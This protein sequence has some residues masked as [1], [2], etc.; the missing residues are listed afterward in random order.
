MSETI[1]FLGL[2][3]ASRIYSKRGAGLI[4]TKVIAVDNVTLGITRGETLALVGES[5]SGKSTTGRMLLGLEQPDTGKLISGI[6]GEKLLQNNKDTIVRA[7]FQNPRSSLNPRRR[8]SSL[9]RESLG[10]KRSGMSRKQVGELVLKTLEEVGL[11][12]EHS[13]VFPHSLSGGQQQRVAIAAAIISEPDFVILDEP[14]SALDPS[15]AAQVL[16]LLVSLGNRRGCGFLFITHDLSM[17]RVISDRIA[18]MYLGRII[19]SGPTSDV[20][21]SPSHPYT[22]A[23]IDS[24]PASHPAYR[25]DAGALPSEAPSPNARPSGCS[26]HPRCKLNDNQLCTTVV[27]PLEN[28]KSQRASAC[29]HPIESDLQA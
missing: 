2:E 26:F 28:R 6:R 21:K 10:S 29:F 7:V 23:L 27:P 9:L 1:A 22:R 5:G 3:D 24:Q 14:V 4:R 25:S 18:V 15:V 11:S 12:P 17:A 13:G 8:V 19:E 16:N 20:L